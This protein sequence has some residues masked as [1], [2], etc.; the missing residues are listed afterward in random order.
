MTVK[1]IFDL[2]KQGKIEEAYDAI[3]PMYAAHKGRYT[4]LCM[5][6]VAHDILLKRLREGRI[7]EARKIYLS[8]QRLVPTLDDRDGKAAEFMQYASRRLAEARA[9]STAPLGAPDLSR[10]CKP[11]DPTPPPL[12][13]P[14]RGDTPPLGQ[15]QKEL[16]T[17]H[18]SLST[19]PDKLSRLLDILQGPMSVREMMASLNFHSRDKFLKNY[20]SPALNSGL[21]EMTDPNSPRSPKQRYRRTQG[22]K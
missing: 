4:T 5:F 3:R 21:V 17:F 14:H 18:S 19:I 22:D 15:T 1:D 10:G 9:T 11:T 16:L 2:R 12:S 20:L 8:L 7:D 6:W 13:E